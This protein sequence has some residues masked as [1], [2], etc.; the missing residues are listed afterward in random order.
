[1]AETRV[2]NGVPVIDRTFDLLDALE[3]APEGLSAPALVEAMA[4][5]RSTVY[6]I[7]NSLLARKVVRRGFHGNFVLGNRLVSLAA[8]V[9]SDPRGVDLAQVATPIM[10]ALSDETG[11]P[12]KLSVR[13]GDQ[14][15][16]IAATIGK[17]DSTFA[18]A[19]ASRYPLHAGAASKVI[20]AHMPAEDLALLLDA[21]FIRY[22]PRTIDDPKHLAAELARVRKRGF[23]NDLG[24]HNGRVHAIAVPVFDTG[25]RFLAA[26]S[27]PFLAD[28]DDSFRLRMRQALAVAAQ[29]IGRQMPAS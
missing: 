20:M 9:R 28:R 3:G 7:L 27:V 6:R 21:P 16:V 4:V 29:A 5:P 24:E 13:D 11:E 10:Q 8:H 19:L 2:R 15:N 26:L 23:A 12:L 22:T 17:P 1:M 14:A 25:G 18:P